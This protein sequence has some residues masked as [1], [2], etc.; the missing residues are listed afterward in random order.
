MNLLRGRTVTG[1]S[2]TV[3][4]LAMTGGDALAQQGG[5]GPTPPPASRMPSPMLPASA[6]TMI[7]LPEQ[8]TTT[9]ITPTSLFKATDPFVDPSNLLPNVYENV[10]SLDGSEIINTLPS[11]PTNPYNLHY[12]EPVIT[13]LANSLSPADD[14]AAIFKGWYTNNQT[15]GNYQ[16]GNPYSQENY[17]Y[18]P[19]YFDAAAIQRGID[20]LEG[21]PIPGR[22]YSGMPVLHIAG[23]DQVGVVKPKYDSVTGKAIGGNI[24]VHQVWFGQHIEEDTS[25]IDTSLMALPENKDLPWTIT[26]TVDVL[27]RG[28]DDF[29]P[30]ELFNSD[31]ELKIGP[32]AGGPLPQVMMDGTFFPMLDGTRNV[33]IIKMPP[34]RFFQLIYS[35]GWRNHPGRIAVMENAGKIAD[36][37]PGGVQQFPDIERNVFRQVNCVSA[38]TDDRPNVH[39]VLVGEA[40]LQGKPLP[41]AQCS[42]GPP[43][44]SSAATKA[45]AISFI[46]DLAPAKRM[47]TALKTLK[48]SGYDPTVM[49]EYE[50][51]FYQWQN[52][53]QLPD[54][55]T[56]DPNADLT[57]A[58]LNNSIYGQLKGMSRLANKPILEQWHMRGTK[59]QVKLFNGDYFPHGYGAVNF[60]GLRG[61]ENLYQSAH[62][63]GGDG[64][65]FTFGR[66]YWGLDTAPKVVV[67]PAAEKS[68]NAVI[69]ATTE[70]MAVMTDRKSMAAKP[71]DPML[72]EALKAK[73]DSKLVKSMRNQTFNFQ[74]DTEEAV[75]QLSIA[76]VPATNGDVLGSWTINFEMNY[77]PSLRLRTYQ[78]DPIHHIQA[79]WAIH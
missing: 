17:H 7:D 30:L 59:L 64:D 69:P 34:A 28:N 43:I 37:G 2:L 33:F 49:A 56:A 21:N 60:G 74:P 36:L 24:N 58:Y 53:L 57:L 75:P 47:W 20:V 6:W 38:F 76:T 4:F 51:A 11:T 45:Y 12:K 15:L 54:G 8:H 22:A 19:E 18:H 61:W 35:W 42:F 1:L 32:T 41:G 14:L 26:Y 68:A 16:P 67:V 3:L 62:P 52:R 23:G 31:P 70:A 25:Y 55:I 77:E 46:G 9:F 66:A 44:M 40:D 73:R 39:A 50:R 13:K 5:P 27:T 71:M 79:I 10:K 29:S 48:S 72:R 65:T 63:V 78:F